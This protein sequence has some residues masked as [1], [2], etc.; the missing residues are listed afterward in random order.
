MGKATIKYWAKVGRRSYG[1]TKG[2]VNV[3][4][5]GSD[6]NLLARLVRARNQEPGSGSGSQA[7]A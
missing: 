6:V 2:T 7:T 4:G 1:H 3:D 5:H